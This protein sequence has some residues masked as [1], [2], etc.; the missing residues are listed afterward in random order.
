MREPELSLVYH[1]AH[2]HAHRPDRRAVLYHLRDRGAGT[3]G[4]R[5]GRLPGGAG[6]LGALSNLIWSRI[7][8]RQGTRRLILLTGVLIVLG[9]ALAGAIGLGSTGLLIAMGLVFLVAGVAT[10]GAGIS[11][12]TYLLE[13][14]PETERPTYIG[15]ANT[16]LGVVT[17][18]PVLGGWLVTTIM[19][20]GAFGIGVTFALLGLAASYQLTETRVR[21]A[22]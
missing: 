10:D 22:T 15:L 14:V 20:G 11:G 17:F 5:R 1:L 4:R 3:A 21:R 13:I 6:G 9:P 7:S 19:Y 18:L 16:T 12:N 8:E 2:A